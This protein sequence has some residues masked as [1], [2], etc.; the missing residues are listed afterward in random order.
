MENVLRGG[1]ELNGV[2]Y[3]EPNGVQSALNVASD[4]V[5]SASA[6]QYGNWFAVSKPCEPLSGGCEIVLILLT[7]K[8]KSSWYANTVP[9][10]TIVKKV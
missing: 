2:K 10:L 1:F 4:V 5:L 8:A 7:V 3:K 6:Q 9:S